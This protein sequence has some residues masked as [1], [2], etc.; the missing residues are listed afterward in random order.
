MAEI[1]SL[2]GGLAG[3]VLAASAW[4][5]VGCTECGGVVCPPCPA[6]FEAHVTD[7]VSGEPVPGVE[8]TGVDGACEQRA[9]LGYTLCEIWLEVGTSELTLSAGGYEDQEL[10]VT[11]NPDPENTCCTCGY[12][13]KRRDVTLTPS[14]AGSG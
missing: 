12:A 5:G 6:P 7:A 2:I 14:N 11:I 1:P 3:L 13:A 8:V 9:D 4:A 10:A